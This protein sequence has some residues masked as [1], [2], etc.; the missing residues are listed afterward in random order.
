MSRSRMGFLICNC[1]LFNATIN[2]KTIQKRRSMFYQ[3]SFH[4]FVS[5]PRNGDCWSMYEHPW[6]N[7]PHKPSEA[8]FNKNSSNGLHHTLQLYSFSTTTPSAAAAAVTGIIMIIIMTISST[9]SS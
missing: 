8:V 2:Y 9:S 3:N 7:A 6:D 5:S 1:I 4:A